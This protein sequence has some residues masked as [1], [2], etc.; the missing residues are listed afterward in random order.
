MDNILEIK[1]LCKY[2]GSTVANKNVN[3]SLKR[4]E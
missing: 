1:G 3:F 4:G 2:F